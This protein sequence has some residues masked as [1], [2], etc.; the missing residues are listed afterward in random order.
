MPQNESL[1]F[2]RWLVNVPVEGSSPMNAQSVSV[3]AADGTMV[4]QVIEAADSEW[5]EYSTSASIQPAKD[6]TVLYPE[7]VYMAEFAKSE[8]TI[9]YDANYSG[10]AAISTT[11]PATWDT[12]GLLGSVATPTRKTYTFEGWFTLPTGGKQVTKSSKYNEDDLAGAVAKLDGEDVPLDTDG[13]TVTL[14]AHWNVKDSDLETLIGDGG[15]LEKDTTGSDDGTDVPK[16]KYWVPKDVQDELDAALAEAKRV[17]ADPNATGEERIA[18]YERL[19]AAEAAYKAAKK[20]G[21]KA[22]DPDDGNGGSG[23]ATKGTSSSSSWKAPTTGDR[24]ADAMILV[25]GVAFISAGF[26]LLAMRMRRRSSGR[27]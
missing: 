10:A 21:T 15:T 22:D 25:G 6:D 9:A 16:D 2:V 13:A 26:I 27:R 11:T 17:A 23:S 5:Y 7:A 12:A 1:Q 4:A 20:P 18:A 14:Y 8:Y 24:L 3:R 19:Q